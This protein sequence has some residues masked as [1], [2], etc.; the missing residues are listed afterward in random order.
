VPHPA[1][2][3]N[4]SSRRPDFSIIN[5]CFSDFG[6]LILDFPMPLRLP[7]KRHFILF[8]ALTAFG[9]AQLGWW[10]IFQV[11]EGARLRQQQNYVWDQQIYTARQWA[12]ANRVSPDVLRKW[13]TIFPDLE[14]APNGSAIV[15]T[16]AAQQRLDHMAGK[17]V[18]MFISEG[19]FFTLLVA[20]AAAYIYWTLHR[21]MNFE[22]RQSMFLSATSHELKTP[23]TSLKLYLDTMKDRDPPPEQRA[24]IVAT[25]QSDV[26]RLSGLIEQLLQA[27]SVMNRARKPLL[28]QTDLAEE[29]R[30]ALGQVKG[31]FSVAGFDLKIRIDENLWAKTEPLRWQIL[32][33]NLL[34]NA[35]K[36]SPRGGT[37]EIALTRE[38]HSARLMVKD[39][40][41]GLPKP[42]L[43][44][45][46][47]RF[48]RVENEDTRSTKGTGLGLYLVRSIALSFGGKTWA[49]SP[50]LGQGA[51]FFV[52]I[53]LEGKV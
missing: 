22:R 32:V 38:S 23:L 24:E 8:L 6:F 33:K 27:Q 43:E 7:F 30:A 10:V 16:A 13:L 34:E 19:A 12:S 26:D 40:G 53:P 5:F 46:F 14:I 3:V 52:E 36:Y 1:A 18:R 45:V 25:M 4:A 48:Y 47:E 21:E 51:S 17:R 31:M 49:E 35:F 11:R 50:G 41:I 20:A 39:H 2:I 37:V 29:T 44:R 28:V 42:E 9:L 15:V